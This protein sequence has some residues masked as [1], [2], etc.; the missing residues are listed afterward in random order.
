MRKNGRLSR[1][2]I[3]LAGFLLFTGCACLNRVPS[4]GL[5]PEEILED[6]EIIT[7]IQGETLEDLEGEEEIF[8][9]MEEISKI[10]IKKLFLILF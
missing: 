6:L 2:A 1:P 10:I 4:A 3:L 8:L 9:L 5:T 7:K